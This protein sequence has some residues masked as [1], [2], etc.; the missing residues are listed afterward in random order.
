[1]ERG[2]DAKQNFRNINILAHSPLDAGLILSGTKIW[3]RFGVN[4]LGTVTEHPIA[5]I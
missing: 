4:N 3:A 5:M 2:L 1:M